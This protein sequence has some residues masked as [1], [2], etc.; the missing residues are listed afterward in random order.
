MVVV[1]VSAFDDDE[2]GGICGGV[3]FDVFDRIPC[4]PSRFKARDVDRNLPIEGDEGVAVAERV[5]SSVGSSSIPPSTLVAPSAATDVLFTTSGC[6]CDVDGI[7]SSC[8]VVVVVAA[9]PSGI[10]S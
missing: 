3:V 5:S 10:E 4:A 1:V 8:G 9:G 7:S 2:C 6:C